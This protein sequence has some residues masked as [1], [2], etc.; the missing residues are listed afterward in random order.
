MIPR[1]QR[2][3]IIFSGV[4]KRTNFK[5]TN[6]RKVTLRIA[7]RCPLSSVKVWCMGTSEIALDTTDPMQ[8][9]GREGEGKGKGRGRER[10]RHKCPATLRTN[11]GSITLGMLLNK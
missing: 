3:Q 1:L 11:L 6:N 10:G 7:Y 4:L 8:G 5:V 2:S 9:K